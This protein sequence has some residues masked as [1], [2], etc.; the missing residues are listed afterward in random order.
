MSRGAVG[1]RGGRLVLHAPLLGVCKHHEVDGRQ[2]DALAQHAAVGHDRHAAVPWLGGQR[3]ARRAPHR[4][5]H[6]R[7]R[8]RAHPPAHAAEGHAMCGERAARHP[9]EL[10]RA[11]VVGAEGKGR[12][13][14][15]LPVAVEQRRAQL[16]QLARRDAAVPRVAERHQAGGGLRREPILLGELR[17][18]EEDQLER[19]DEPAGHRV[20]VRQPVRHAPKQR[21]VVHRGRRQ[22]LALLVALCA[23]GPWGRRQEQAA[24]GAQEAIGERLRVALGAS[25]GAAVRLVANLHRAGERRAGVGLGSC[26]GASE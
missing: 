23:E 17:Q 10:G 3:R 12:P 5:E 4:V 18:V 21:L 15:M 19:R 7:P 26:K 24:R 13:H 22:E 14:A 11:G 1:K 8:R 9:F 2:V 6:T 20:R 16:R 25:A